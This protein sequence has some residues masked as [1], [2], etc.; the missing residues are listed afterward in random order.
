LPPSAISD[1]WE[2]LHRRI[3]EIRDAVHYLRDTWATDE[4]IDE[5]NRYAAGRS[6]LAVACWLE[7]TRRAAVADAPKLHRVLEALP[8][9]A[10]STMRAEIAWHIRLY[11]A[12][13]SRA[14]H[15]FA[16]RMPTGTDSPARPEL[17]SGYC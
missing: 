14:V 7:V 15:T 12:M 2:S 3:V 4:L 16:D 5:A 13:N 8:D 1:S 11:R 17:T 10:E 9:S 6:E